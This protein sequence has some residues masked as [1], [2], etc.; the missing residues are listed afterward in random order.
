MA[1][2]ARLKNE[3]TEDK[4]NHNLMTWLIFCLSHCVF[5][6]K[7]LLG[8][9]FRQLQSAMFDFDSF[10]TRADCALCGNNAGRFVSPV[11][12]SGKSDS[13]SFSRGNIDPVQEKRC[14][15]FFFLSN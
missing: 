14:F 3:F 13:Y 7:M 8:E 12:I 4:K 1:A 15:H 6:P 10:T 11:C 9:L 5:R 2:H